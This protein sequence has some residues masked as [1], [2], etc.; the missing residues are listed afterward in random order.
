MLTEE[1][2]FA[3]I[4]CRKRWYSKRRRN[5]RRVFNLVRSNRALDDLLDIV[6]RVI[7]DNIRIYKTL[8]CTYCLSPIKFGHQ[9]IDHI[10]PLNHFGYNTRYANLVV[11]C[12]SCVGD[13][14][15]SSAEKNRNLEKFFR[16]RDALGLIESVNNLRVI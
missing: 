2:R 4:A 13:S 14:G 5:A 12:M 15:I 11:S 9:T 10:K 1:Q 6:Q 8:T 16:L 3:R 7:E